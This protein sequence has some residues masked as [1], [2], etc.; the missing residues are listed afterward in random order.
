MLVTTSNGT[1][2]RLCLQAEKEIFLGFVGLV[3]ERMIQV[4]SIG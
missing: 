2:T 1:L 3:F 4:A